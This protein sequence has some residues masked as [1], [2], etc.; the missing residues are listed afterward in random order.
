MDVLR[1]GAPSS[2]AHHRVRSESGFTLLE[3]I[4]TISI[5]LVLAVSGW[6]V[7][8]QFVDRARTAKVESVADEAF[9]MAQVSTIELVAEHSTLAD[10]SLGEDSNPARF[11]STR[12]ISF[13]NIEEQLSNDTIYVKIERTDTALTA[14]AYGW[15]EQYIAVRSSDAEIQRSAT[16][17]E[18]LLPDHMRE[19]IFQ[20]TTPYANTKMKFRGVS[21]DAT[22]E[23][24]EFGVREFSPP[25]NGIYTFPHAGTYTIRG[26]FEMIGA[27]EPF[28]NT[29]DLTY[30]QQIL[31]ANA[32]PFRGG[33]TIDK[34][35]NTKTTHVMRAFER[36]N[37]DYIAEPPSTVVNMN[38]LFREATHIP[39]NIVEWDISN[40]QNLSYMFNG[41]RSFNHDIGNWNPAS[42]EYM[43][44]MFQ[45]ASGFNQ[46]ISAWD[47]SNVRYMGYMF[48][49]ASRF[50]NGGAPLD[51]NLERVEDIHSMFDN[52]HDFSQDI[53]G[54][55]LPNLQTFDR[56]FFAMNSGISGRWHMYPQQFGEQTTVIY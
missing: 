46:D 29:E 23:H 16:P 30:S 1:T 40:V 45:S 43:Q 4:T 13:A 7:T 25:W 55:K 41:A 5:I 35:Q 20:F 17:P 33:A 50:N 32:S 10:K 11:S 24:K 8:E 44:R 18:T 26:E 47:V 27:D 49:A 36:S 52:A 31:Q 53:S 21:S 22:I 6:F 37:M 56:R 54:W 51:W 14:V 34:W 2:G 3:V 39:E 9:N 19:P 48:F 28:G 15:D 38:A 42:A 12:K